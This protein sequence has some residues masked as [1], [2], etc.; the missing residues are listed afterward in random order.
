MSAETQSRPYRQVARAAAT[1]ETR[2]RIVTAFAEAL[3]QRWLDEI[4]LDE[5]ATAAGTTRQTVI[6]L[7]GGKEGLL[8]A[9]VDWMRE[10]VVIRR[11]LMPGPTA[12]AVAR[13]VGADYETSGDMLIRLLAQEGRHPGLF[14]LLD[15]GRRHH[16]TWI[17]EVLAGPIAS[18]P[19]AEREALTDRLIVATDVYSWKLLRRDAGRSRIETEAAIAALIAAILAARSNDHG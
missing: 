12:I 3:A 17:G 9:V 2:R 19:P 10:G 15:L 11:T 8:D 16:R 7:F 4:T 5:L 13:A 1:E 14:T 18:H 6:R